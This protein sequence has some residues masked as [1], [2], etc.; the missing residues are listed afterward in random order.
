MDVEVSMKR[1]SKL[2]DESGMATLEMVPLILVFMVIAAYTFG[3]FGVTH[4]AILNSI[5]ARN[6][7]F[8]TFRH[9]ADLT[10]FRSNGTPDKMFFSRVGTRIHGIVS[11]ANPNET[12]AGSF[13]ATERR[14]A[15]GLDSGA[16]ERD[17]ANVDQSRANLT[18]H[19][20]NVFKIQR[21]AQNESIGVSPVW[22]MT[23]YGI[24]LNARCGDPN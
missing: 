18:L 8:E 21:N 2:K 1:R 16:I 4:T 23:Q 15:M 11:D 12:A 24:C 7:A 19:N 6:Y 3:M 13:P 17:L 20:E 22:V 14:I 9:R 10:Y 5:A